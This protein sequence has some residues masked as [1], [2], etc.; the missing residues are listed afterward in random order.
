MARVRIRRSHCLGSVSIPCSKSDAHR[1]IIAAGLAFGETSRVDRIDF[2]DDLRHT[3]DAMRFFGEIG[4]FDH[5][6]EIH[7]AI[8]EKRTAFFDAGESGST[9]RFLL[10]LFAHFFEFTRIKAQ[11]RLLERPLDIYREIFRE[12]LKIGEEIELTGGLDHGDYRVYGNLSS[13]FVSGLLFALPLL[14]GDSTISVSGKF[15]SKPYVDMTM[16]TLEKAGIRIEEK[17]NS[18]FIRGNQRYKKGLYRVEG[19][20]SQLAFFAVLG[21]INSPIHVDI[22]PKSTRQGD[23]RIISI[24]RDFNGKVVEDERGYDFY[25]SNLK[26]AQVDLSDQPDLGPILFVLALFAEGTSRFYNVRRLRYKECDRIAAMKS[27]LKKFGA[28]IQD[29]ENEVRINGQ[30]VHTPVQVIDAH[31]DHRILMALSILATMTDRTVLEDS[32]C[33]RKSYP[34]F[35]RDLKRIGIEVENDD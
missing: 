19:D 29:E 24:I 28:E 11:R 35:F 5:S 10:P 23:A 26:A 27:E 2:S 1:K 12:R 32:D 33:V 15:E 14:K 18:Y 4:V 9:L 8:P 16:A 7:S 20:Y 34:N 31:G 6:V 13:Q 22:D 21:Q 17:N 25:P 30:R 3:L